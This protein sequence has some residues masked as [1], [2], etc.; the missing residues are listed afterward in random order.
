[1]AKAQTLG[2]CG[3][4][5]HVVYSTQ[6][7]ALRAY[8][9]SHACLVIV[10]SVCKTRWSGN[11]EPLFLCSLAVCPGMVGST[12]DGIC[13]WKQTSLPKSRFTVFCRGC[14]ERSYCM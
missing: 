9:R 13:S 3:K 10:V 4:V 14:S 7:I 6:A 1:M 2:M 5:R 8:L 11:P 12:H